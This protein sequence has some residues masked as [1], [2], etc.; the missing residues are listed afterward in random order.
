MFDLIYHCIVLQHRPRCRKSV[1]ACREIAI[2]LRASLHKTQRNTEHRGHL[3]VRIASRI[4][5]LFG[6][7]RFRVQPQ[8]R[9]LLRERER[10]GIVDVPPGCHRRVL[11]LSYPRHHVILLP[12]HNVDNLTVAETRP[13][14]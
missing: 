12:T 6:L 11:L 8:I 3:G 10:P 4:S 14:G 9:R 1:R 13:V 5:A 2:S 7:W